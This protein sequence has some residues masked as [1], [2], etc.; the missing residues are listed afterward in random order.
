[1]KEYLIWREK[2]GF[3]YAIDKEYHLCIWSLFTGELLYEKQLD[4]P[5]EIT[6]NYSYDSI[7][8]LNTFSD[9][10]EIPSKKDYADYSVN[11][12]KAKRYNHFLVLKLQVYGDNQDDL[13]KE[14]KAAGLLQVLF[15]FDLEEYED[16]DDN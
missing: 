4:R 5:V 16:N 2:N 3:F 1:M 15:E 14:I 11:I 9:V 7:R 13:N 8:Y 12:V 6:G 10:V